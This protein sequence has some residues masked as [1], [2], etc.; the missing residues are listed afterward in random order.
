ME[1]TL[2][3]HLNSQQH[4]LRIME[5]HGILAGRFIADEE[6]R[7]AAIAEAQRARLLIEAGI[8]P[9]GAMPFRSTALR[10]VGDALVRLGTRL[11]GS[12]AAHA[13]PPEVSSKALRP[14]MDQA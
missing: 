4:I 12:Y 13:S 5:N 11:Q 3:R 9:P 2:N 10:S 14:T 7:Q 8:T 6:I 1:V